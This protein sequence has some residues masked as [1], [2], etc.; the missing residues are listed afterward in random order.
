M[1]GRELVRGREVGV[2]E[3]LTQA[4]LEDALE[5][6]L[7]RIVAKAQAGERLTVRERE[8]VEAARA[9]L[10][11]AGEPPES[12]SAL[13]GG[14]VTIDGIQPVIAERYRVSE[15]TLKGWIRRGRDLG[16]PCPFRRPAEMP[17]WYERCFPDR[18]CPEKVMAAID[19]LLAGAETDAA[20]AESVPA[21]NDW[22][23]EIDEG[24]MGIAA[25]LSRARRHEAMVYRLFVA[26]ME[27][28]ETD[29]AAFLQKQWGDAAEKLRAIEKMAPKALEELGVYVRKDEVKRE[30]SVIFGSVLKVF[31]AEFRAARGKLMKVEGQGAWDRAVGDVV[32]K[33]K[34]L[35][36]ESSFA[37]PL[38]LAA[39]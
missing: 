24:E 6:D 17:A 28:N 37:E 1:H 11:P 7:G 3:T 10:A 39:E 12:V 35:L 38:E 4:S 18:R 31:E 25:M 8:I 15:R 5:R 21:G 34:A 36:L 16:D 14:G 33:A 32:E 29:R 30:V 9:D 26:A 2:A 13:R 19:D 27:K 22:K 23:V 20:P